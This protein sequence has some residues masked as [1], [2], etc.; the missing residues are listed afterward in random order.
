MKTLRLLLS[1]IFIVKLV[2]GGRGL[3]EPWV[4][5]S[6]WLRLSKLWPDVR[7]FKSTLPPPAGLGVKG[8][9]Q[10]L[11][12]TYSFSAS[13]EPRIL[14][15]DITHITGKP[16]FNTSQLRGNNLIHVPE[17]NISSRYLCTSFPQNPS[18]PG[19]R[20]KSTPEPPSCHPPTPSPA[21]TPPDSSHQPPLSLSD[22]D[23]G[24]A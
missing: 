19:Y 4:S 21:A 8:R 7:P 20:F 2:G 17:E 15:H 23:I 13:R 11:A 22:L 12:V 9:C 24:R 14:H 1:L 3:L 10:Y 6:S 5:R 18:Q 16:Y